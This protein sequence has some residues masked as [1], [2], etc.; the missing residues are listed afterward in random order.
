LPIFVIT[1][2][3]HARGCASEVKQLVYNNFEILGFVNPG[4]RIEFIKDTAR[5]NIQQLTWKYVVVLWGAVMMCQE[6]TQL[7]E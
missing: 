6:I 2:N 4:V 3:S 5:V 1:G 7:R